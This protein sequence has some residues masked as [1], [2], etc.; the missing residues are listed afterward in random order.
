MP[1]IRDFRADFRRGRTGG[2]LQVRQDA[3]SYQ[4]S[5][6]DA[7]NMMVLADGRIAKRWGTYVAHDM[8]NNDYTKRIVPWEH[9]TNGTNYMIAYQTAGNSDASINVFV[10]DEYGNLELVYDLLGYNTDLTDGTWHPANSTSWLG[11]VNNIDYLNFV[12][13]EDKLLV[14]DNTI[15]PLWIQGSGTNTTS[16][17]IVEVLEHKYF[18]LDSNEDGTKKAPFYNFEETL[19]LTPNIFTIEGLST[20][21][22]D[23]LNTLSQFTN[24]EYDL[25]AGTGKVTASADFFTSDHVGQ[26][27]QLLDGEFE[28]TG[29]TSAT[30]ASIKVRKNIAKRLDNNPFL[31]K[32]NKK[33]VEVSYFNHG[34]S[35]GDEIFLIGVSADD[36]SN[37]VLTKAL[38][39]ATDGTTVLANAN[40][41]KYTVD[42]VIDLDTFVI[43]GAVNATNDALIGG[44]SVYC[45][46][47]GGIKGVKEEAFSKTRGWPTCAVVHE[48]RLWMAGTTSLPNAI[49]AS[50]FG[51]VQNFDTGEGNLTDAIAMYGVG[52]EAVFIRHMI[53]GFDLVL[54][55][56]EAELYIPGSTTEAISQSTVRV[57]RAT[58]HGSSYTEPAK[59]DGGVFFVDKNGKEIRE[60]VTDTRITDYHSIPSSI[61]IPD[62][63]KSPKKTAVFMGASE[64]QTTPYMFFA[65]QTDGSM[66]CMHSARVDDSFGFMR[67]S[68]DFGTITD[69]ATLGEHLYVLAERRSDNKYENGVLVE[70]TSSS[71]QSVI[72]KFDT[73]TKNY[74]TT[75]FSSIMKLMSGQ[76]GVGGGTTYPR[77]QG[78]CLSSQNQRYVYVYSNSDGNY[79]Y[80]E[81]YWDAFSQW[82]DDDYFSDAVFYNSGGTE[83][84]TPVIG[85]KMTAYAKLHAP[86]AQLPSGTRI[87]KK[88]RLVSTDVSF[89]GTGDGIIAG[90]DIVRKS[91]YRATTVNFMSQD[92][93]FIHPID[94][95]REIYVGEWTRDPALE[96]RADKTGVLIIRGMSLNVYV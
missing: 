77:Q 34:F 69:V 70:D 28:I 63:V 21:F 4:S 91:D 35:K 67:W 73:D 57:V 62:W 80:K 26:N 1:K 6:R 96:V 58:E 52:D 13:V 36:E 89:E 55:S 61:V 78:R 2:A 87:G 23:K 15:R 37:T 72:L 29:I 41:D 64:N 76:W 44:N 22:N 66:I 46:R 45:F 31:M 43:T 16:T 20:G 47:L 24:G 30:V 95:W 75:D 81:F 79:F 65:D 39:T 3:T 82:I 93:V 85:D 60:F 49:W 33:T 48:R 74:I 38:Q 84:I 7:N 50:Q 11:H 86:I 94:E 92:K 5:V 17:P 27:M 68:L 9:P 18:E 56:D 51:D 88:Q 53:S 59:F 8:H 54:M 90:R 42:N 14:V 83:Y 32:K 19:T 12:K 71:M 40:F 10:Q 25:A